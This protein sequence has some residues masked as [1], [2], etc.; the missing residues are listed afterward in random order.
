MKCA[1]R[2]ILTITVVGVLVLTGPREAQAQA[3]FGAEVL[4][5]TETDVGLGGRVHVPLDLGVP[6]LEFMGSFNLFFPDG[7]ADYWEINGNVWYRIET[8]GRSRALPYVGGGLNIG[9]WSREDFD[10]TDLGLNLG[11]GVRF[12]FENTTPFLEARFTIG[13]EEQFVIGGGV[14]F[15]GS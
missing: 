7:P 9:R 2:G 4:F 13:G 15:G 5:G 12:P 3:L 6:N 1:L 10:D 11:G 8:S 14:L